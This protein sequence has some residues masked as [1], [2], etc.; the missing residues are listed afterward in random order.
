MRQL[1]RLLI[2]HCQIDLQIG[3]WR[4]SAKGPVAVIALLLIIVLI[5]H[6]WPLPLP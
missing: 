2:E 5:I 1:L 3:Q 6:R 4:L